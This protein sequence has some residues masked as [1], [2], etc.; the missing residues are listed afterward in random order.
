MEPLI[1]LVAVCVLGTVS[2]IAYAAGRSRTRRDLLEWAESHKTRADQAV[3]A[4]ET[5]VNQRDRTR[6]RYEEVLG[7]YRAAKLDRDQSSTE[8]AMYRRL[9]DRLGLRTTRDGEWAVPNLDRLHHPDFPGP[10][11]LLRT[12]AVRWGEL[13]ASSDGLGVDERTAG[14]CYLAR[15]NSDAMRAEIMATVAPATDIQPNIR[16][17]RYSDGREIEIDI[18]DPT[19]WPKEVKSINGVTR[20]EIKQLPDG[21]MFQIDLAAMPV[22]LENR[23]RG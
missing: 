2:L 12:G 6:D 4:Y 22:Q 1:A 14:N 5:A 17:L 11:P 9:R 10:A 20:E 23:D 16:T 8:L 18:M 7:E 21:R 3:H 13:G 15:V 19:T